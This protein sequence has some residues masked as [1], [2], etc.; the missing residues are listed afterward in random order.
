MAEVR[1]RFAP[2]PTGGLHL[3]SALVALAAW[4]SVRRRGGAL[5]WRVEDLDGPRVV[6]G[7][8]ARQAAEARWLGLD[9]D[10]GPDVGGPH[11]P[12]RQSERGAHYE[13][14]LARLAAAG[15]LFPCRRSRKDLLGLATAPH[16]RE[17]LPPYPAAFR[18]KHL[19]PGWFDAYRADPSPDA[20]LR[21]RVASG[22]V[23]FE[24]RVQ[25]TVTEDV[26]TEVGD[27]V[28]RRRDGVYA[29]QLAVVVDDLAMGI[30]EVV[31]GADLLDSTARQ[32]Q[33]IEA[34]GGAPPA[35]AHLPLAVNEAGEKLSKRDDA[36]SVTALRD[37]GVAPE[38]VVGWLAWALGQ[39]D[40]PAPVTPGA[41]VAAFGW[42][43][44]PAAPVVVPADLPVRLG[45][46]AW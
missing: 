18:P 29:Y 12:Y 22:P 36:L 37:A 39:Q 4:L 17:G 41:L 35:Y 40:T 28:L 26:A 6:P 33:L 38:A 3:G 16:G 13:A 1:G 20:A 30:T 44:V 43:R 8:A 42:D 19:P 25:G 7:A 45:A 5:V 27:F 32:V 23:T 24:D 15:R 9:W 31:R 11:A 46:G 10:E 14:A 2:S 34:L 21:F